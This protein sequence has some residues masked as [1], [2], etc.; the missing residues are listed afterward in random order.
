MSLS[1]KEIGMIPSSDPFATIMPEEKTAPAK[2][3]KKSKK[4]SKKAKKGEGASKGTR[5]S[6]K[7]AKTATDFVVFKNIKPFGVS[8]SILG[9]KI[10]MSEDGKMAIGEKITAFGESLL[11]KASDLANHRKKNVGEKAKSIFSTDISMAYG[12]LQRQIC[13][14]KT[15]QLSTDNRKSADNT[16]RIDLGMYKTSFN[17]KAGITRAIRTLTDKNA[18]AGAVN[19]LRL[20]LNYYATYILKKAAENVAMR[21]NVK[22]MPVHLQNIK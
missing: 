6:A 10:Q 12:D 17:T 11:S 5:K 19:A 15:M 7:S 14:M 3:G 4:S 16:A 9:A 18:T 2:A 20:A 13:D 22:I 21:E 1:G 8:I